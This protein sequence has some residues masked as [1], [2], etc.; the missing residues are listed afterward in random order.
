[1]AVTCDLYG[2]LAG[3]PPKPL[4]KWDSEIRGRHASPAFVRTQG[5]RESLAPLPSYW[6]L[7][8]ST[9]TVTRPPPPR[10]QPSEL[11]R[12]G[13]LRLRLGPQEAEDL[14][15]QQIG[16]DIVLGYVAVV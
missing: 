1:M 5:S 14:L 6:I 8:N 12:F 15:D 3:P 2:L 9:G 13:G 11:S 16:G 7:S 10:P 4:N